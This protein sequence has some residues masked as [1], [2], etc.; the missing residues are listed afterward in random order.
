MPNERKT[1][2]G[3]GFTATVFGEHDCAFELNAGGR[4]RMRLG[5]TRCGGF[6]ETGALLKKL[7]FHKSLDRLSASIET[8]SV[9]PFG[10]EYKV[11]RNLEA[12]AGLALWTVDV[13][14]ETRGI[15]S[16]VELEPVIFPGPWKTL[17][18]LVY[19][20]EAFRKVELE[21][22]DAEFHCGRELVVTIRLTA[23][24]GA[25]VEFNAGGDLW[26]H[27]AA[28]HNPEIAG[29]YLLAGSAS[30]LVFRRK[31]FA[32]PAEAVIAKRPWRFKNSFAWTLPGDRFA[33]PGEEAILDFAAE[34][35]PESARRVGCGGAMEAS[36]CMTSA[37][38]RRMFRDFVRRGGDADLRIA[39]LPSGCCCAAAHLERPNKGEL[40][41]F[42]LDDSIGFYL[43]GNRQLAK[44][45]HHLR[46]A[47]AAEGPF[48]GSVSAAVLQWAPRF[49]LEEQETE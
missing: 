47:P 29:E 2:A 11:A 45:G 32:F 31:V 3:P 1:I 24:D 28:M 4:V 15:V 8:A 17:E 42:D 18:Y 35:L 30:Q 23:D 13:S 37:V 7:R 34:E 12:M 38:A 16:A 19:G 6:D 40:E 21:A 36:P 22:E 26:R 27:R 44:K 20:E 43:W 46:I 48:A 9:I 5:R 33:E 14:A 49:P 39:G 25:R 10:C 41:H